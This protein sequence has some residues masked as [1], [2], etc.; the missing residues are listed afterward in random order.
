[1]VPHS[2]GDYAWN[3]RLLP[4][5]GQFP[6]GGE[7]SLLGTHEAEYYGNCRLSALGELRWDLLSRWMADAYV[8]ALY[9]VGAVTPASEPVPQSDDYLHGIG[10]S[11]GLSTF[12]GPLTLTVGHLLEGPHTTDNTHLYI[13]LGHRF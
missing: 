8:S 1:M 4:L 5:W 9:T 11:V 6:L 2:H 3:D 7:E 13:N 10:G 12:V